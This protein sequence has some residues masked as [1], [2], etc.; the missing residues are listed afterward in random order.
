MLIGFGISP[1]RVKV[2]GG[3]AA[4]DADAQAFFTAASITD[5]TQ[6]SAVNQLVLD[7]KSY[8]IW[9]KMK[10][11]YP[12][13]GGS[14]ATHKWNLKDPRDLNAAYRLLFT[15]GWT[16]SSTGMLPNGTSAYA[17]T[18]LNGTTALT[19]NNS[20]VSFYSRTNSDNIG[21]DFGNT[22]NAF[23]SITRSAN[24]LISDFLGNGSQFSASPDRL[25]PANT[26]S[27]AFF[28]FSSTSTNI[29]IYKNN[30]TLV[31]KGS[32]TASAYPNTEILLSYGTT[33]GANRYSNRE[34]SFASIGDGLSDA[35]ASNFRT[36]V[37]AYQT[38][39]SRNV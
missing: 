26:S 18:S 37:Q 20:H 31:S 7:L 10:A 25:Q 36:A 8:N 14:A 35:E 21:M 4:F 28:I 32:A 12:I 16:H 9:S 33:S 6:K 11:I 29:K 15:T 27:N 1:S 19:A 34:L 5:S 17:Q 38:T 13:V 24:A 3:A 2:T 30:T 22:A 39:L 23:G